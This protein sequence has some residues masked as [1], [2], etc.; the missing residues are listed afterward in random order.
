[1][2]TDD[3]IQKRIN[4]LQ[5][6]IYDLNDKIDNTIS[7][8]EIKKIDKIKSKLYKEKMKLLNKLYPQ[9]AAGEID[10]ETIV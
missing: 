4:Q 5:Q 1:M 10:D 2:T 6:R 9:E 7:S 3:K 8:S